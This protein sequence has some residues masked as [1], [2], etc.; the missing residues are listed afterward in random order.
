MCTSIL[1]LPSL[2]LCCCFARELWRGS[3][4][5]S[6]DSSTWALSDIS[7]RIRPLL[8][9]AFLSI[10]GSSRPS[11]KWNKQKC[12]HTCPGAGRGTITCVEI[13]WGGHSTNL[14]SQREREAPG[15]QLLNAGLCKPREA[16]RVGAELLTLLWFPRPLS[17]LPGSRGA[18]I[19]FHV[20]SVVS[21]LFVYEGNL[22]ISLLPS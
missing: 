18:C 17:P 13:C 22:L 5:Q 7:S 15:C 8:W 9:V 11:C 21:L 12:F 1:A 16:P 3:E 14:L 20:I 19:L 2:S 4:G 6:R 10:S